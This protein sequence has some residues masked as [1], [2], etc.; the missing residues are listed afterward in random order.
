MIGADGAELY[1][2]TVLAIFST[3][4]IVEARIYSNE[5]QEYGSAIIQRLFRQIKL[6]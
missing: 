5:E 1:G 6:L 3:A 2:R 4:H